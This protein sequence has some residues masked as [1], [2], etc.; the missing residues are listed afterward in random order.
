[1]IKFT[2]IIAEYNPFHNGHK[3]QIEHLR[4]LGT[5]VVAVAMS[6]N[7]VQ[8]GAPAW[9]DKY[10][11]AQMA[12]SQG[13][14]LVFELPTVYALSSA[15]H[16]AFGGISLLNALHMD[17]FC[18]GC[19]TPSLSLLDSAATLL[20]K[21][22]AGYRQTLQAHIKTGASYPAAREVALR[23]SMPELPPDFLSGANNIL[24]LEYLKALKTTHSTMTP[25]PILRTDSGYH[26]TELSG[27]TFS[28]A[29]AIRSS[30]NETKSLKDVSHALPEE[31]LA[32]L[33]DRSGRFGM[34]TADFDTLLY[35][36]LRRAVRKGTLT[37][38]GDMN[39]ELANR[40]EKSLAEY[41]TAEKFIL[42]LKR[43]N[44]TYSRICR[45]LFQLLLEIPSEYVNGT[46]HPVPYLRLLGMRRQSSSYLRRI[47]DVPVLTKMADARDILSDSP[48][49]YAKDFLS[50][51][52]FAAD[53][54]RQT[55]LQKTSI[56]I[57]DEYHAGI[58]IAD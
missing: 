58:V 55:L 18:F 21:E 39:E 51:D 35:Y 24:A 1:M 27:G 19:E 54:Y 46:S 50:I 5:E 17:S 47:T 36:S 28:S 31:V 4:S 25:V 30:Y 44:I 29:S 6:G 13:A 14:D 37:H 2:G 9:A 33:E 8:R 22:P 48:Y 20:Q 12:L 43:K 10:T 15:E 34:D 57:P 49:P 3:H 26:S 23:Q 41:Q 32:L 45:C 52:F 16:F 53:L 56:A 7:F 42:S 38:Y 11:R 40:I